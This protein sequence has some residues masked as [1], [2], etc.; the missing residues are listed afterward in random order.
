MALCLLASLLLCINMKCNR[1]VFILSLERITYDY[2]IRSV[3]ETISVSVH[4]RYSL[5]P[6]FHNVALERLIM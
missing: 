1:A 2:L 4:M 5:I 6:A 3:S